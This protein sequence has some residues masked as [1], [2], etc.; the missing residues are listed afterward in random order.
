VKIPAATITFCGVAQILEPEETPPDIVKALT[1]GMVVDQEVMSNSSLIEFTPIKE[2]VTYGVGISL[3]Q[4][5]DPELA[6][7]RAPVEV[8]A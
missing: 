4:M 1:R 6:R 3:M 2:F 8:P 7:G 5:R